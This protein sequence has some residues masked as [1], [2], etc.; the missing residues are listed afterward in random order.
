MKIWKLILS[1]ALVVAALLILTSC[2]TSP[3]ALEEDDPL[4]GTWINEEYDQSTRSDL[5]SKI[6]VYPDGHEFD[7]KHIGDSEPVWE[8]WYTVEKAWI[9]EEENH[10]YKLQY[11][12]W[13]YPSGVGKEEWFLMIRISTD[14]NTYESVMAQYGYPDD[15]TPL[16]PSFRI[17]QKFK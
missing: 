5:Y 6:I 15:V 12:G 8:A 14:G 11:V 7:Y 17:M 16:G 13:A 10:W 2:A 4:F 3:A 9:D 1:G